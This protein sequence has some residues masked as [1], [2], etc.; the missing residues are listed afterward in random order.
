MNGFV[1]ILRRRW[2]VLVAL[3]IL[4]TIAGAVVTPIILRRQGTPDRL[5][6]QEPPA[7]ATSPRTVPEGEYRSENLRTQFRKPEPSG[8]EEEDTSPA[9]RDDGL[10]Y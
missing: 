6:S 10:M 9:P 5:R 1:A 7:E 3:A 8:E 2:L 4:G